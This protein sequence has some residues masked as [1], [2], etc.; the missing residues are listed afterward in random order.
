MLTTSTRPSGTCRSKYFPPTDHPLT[1]NEK[2]TISST[3][4]YLGCYGQTCVVTGGVAGCPGLGASYAFDSATTL[5]GYNT[6]VVGSASNPAGR[7]CAV[8]CA[9]KVNTN[10][11]GLVNLAGSTT[12]VTCY[13]GERITNGGIFFQETN[14][15]PCNGAGGTGTCGASG[16]SLAVY[17]RA[18]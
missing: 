2:S 15:V 6:T 10:F 8:I 16:V 7:Q 9:T 4:A 13:C 12:A 18:F 5:G 17:G 14:C 11:F 3:F 1:D